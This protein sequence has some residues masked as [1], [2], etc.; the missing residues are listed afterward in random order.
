MLDGD[1]RKIETL[2][3]QWSRARQEK[4]PI[5]YKDRFFFYM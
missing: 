3:G 1:D 2:W 5:S 4:E